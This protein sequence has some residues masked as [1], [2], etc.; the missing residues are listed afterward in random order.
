MKDC[1]AWYGYIASYSADMYTVGS[2]F[3]TVC[4]TTIHLY[5]PC[6]VG[7]STAYSCVTVAAQASFLYLV[8]F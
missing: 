3:A 2:R 7:P 8:R 1:E 5:D 4:F 6:R